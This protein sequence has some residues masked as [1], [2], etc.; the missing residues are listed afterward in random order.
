[1]DVAKHPSVG[2]CWNCNNED[3]GGAGLA[4]NFK[5]VRDRFGD[6][7]HVREF[8]VGKY[9]YPQ[10]MDL[11]KKSDY[12]GWVLLECRTRPKDRIAALIEQREIFKKMLS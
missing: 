1:M 11:L 12:A 3:L 7:V 4:A 10:L 6:T 9:P 2:V 8:N 5:M